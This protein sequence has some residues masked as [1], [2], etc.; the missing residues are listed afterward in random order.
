MLP[1]TRPSHA[2]CFCALLLGLYLGTS[3]L[4]FQEPA[5]APAPPPTEVPE[6]EKPNLADVVGV[7]E[8]VF[9]ERPFAEDP[10]YY[11]NFGYYC[12]EPE[13]KAYSIGG[14]LCRMNLRTGKVTALVDDPQGSVRDPQMHYD[15]QKI[16]FSYRKGGEDQFHL[17][18][19]NV[20]GSNLR[21]LT[22]G[23]YD[24]IEPTYLPDGHI[25]F[26]SS[27]CKRWVMC[28]KVPVAILYKCDADGKNIEM[29][30]SNAVTENTPSVL[31]D[32]RILY[33]GGNT[34]NGASLLI[35]TSGPSTPTGQ[36]R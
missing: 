16:L 10:H 20:D 4:A 7:E 23:K 18:E 27:R 17:Y 31:P 26:C 15:G 13:K 21:Q 9:A 35:I 3:A 25:V 28:W 29:L 36:A 32:G 33:T 30:S 1:H 5:T 24:D 6:A 22:D 2:C 12:Q 34:S 8:I 11:A 19:I 14:R